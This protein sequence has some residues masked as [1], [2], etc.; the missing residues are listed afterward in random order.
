MGK[1]P[2][3]YDML[4]A[5]KALALSDSLS[6]PDKRVATAI[7]DSFNQQS[8]QCDPSFNRI[9]HLV[10][11]SRSTV[12]RSVGRLVRIN[13]LIK[14]TRGGNYQRN[15]YTPNWKWFRDFETNWALRKKTKHWAALDSD[16]LTPSKVSTQETSSGVT[17]DTQTSLINKSNLTFGASMPN[18][19]PALGPGF[20]R[21]RRQAEQAWYAELHEN[22]ST[23]FRQYGELIEAITPDLQ[24]RATD[25]ELQ[26]K[27]AGLELVLCELSAARK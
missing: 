11:L 12:I 27:G 16:N 14:A 20:K 3:R 7:V 4:L 17:A 10:G 23:D 5:F 26:S 15:S 2:R 6:S 25:A 24:E 9:V 21:A 8:G 18:R 13:V 1:L 22:F 19:S